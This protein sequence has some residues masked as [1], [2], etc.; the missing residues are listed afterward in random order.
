MESIW[1]SRKVIQTDY[2]SKYKIRYKFE[3]KMVN[4]VLSE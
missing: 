2:N 4:Q 1:S 3:L